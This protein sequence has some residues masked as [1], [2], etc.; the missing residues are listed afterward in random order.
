[1]PGSRFNPRTKIGQ[2]LRRLRRNKD[3]TGADDLVVVKS[4]ELDVNEDRGRGQNRKLQDDEQ[5][6]LNGREVLGTIQPAEDGP[7]AYLTLGDVVWKAALD[8]RGASYTLEN[9]NDPEQRVRWYV[10]KSKRTGDM[11]QG[12]REFSFATLLPGTKRHPIVANMSEGHLE[13]YEEFSSPLSPHE[14]IKT[15]DAM[16]KLIIVSAMWVYFCEGW[17]KHYDFN[18]A[19]AS[20]TRPVLGRSLSMRSTNGGGLRGI[21]RSPS[22]SPAPSVRGENCFSASSDTRSREGSHDSTATTVSPVGTIRHSMQHCSQI[23]TSQPGSRAASP[24]PNAKERRRWSIANHLRRF[25]HSMRHTKEQIS[26]EQEGTIITADIIHVETLESP[27]DIEQH[28]LQNAFITTAKVIAQSTTTAL[29]DYIHDLPPQRAPATRLKKVLIERTNS[30]ID[31]DDSPDLETIAQLPTPAWT[32]EVR[33]PEKMTASPIS[34]DGDLH[35]A[36]WW[37]QY[38]NFVLR[39]QP[40]PIVI[41]TS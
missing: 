24:E 4:E 22:R 34:S 9:A 5:E 37:Q 27:V 31:M 28:P 30:P 29:T 38:D 35:D 18:T 32:P 10:P 19:V 15:D 26:P 23:P 36:A 21:L 16:R 40:A 39:Q 13:F 33:T 14:T 6:T 17:S 1:V 11:S 20:A 8:G 41:P 12:P 3:G 7:S 2:K 25:S